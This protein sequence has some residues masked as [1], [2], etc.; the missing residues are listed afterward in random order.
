MEKKLKQVTDNIHETI[1][2]ST[3]ES[4]LISTPYFYRLHDIY[5]S[6]TVY[7]TFPTNRTKRYEHS[8]GTMEVASSM[9]YSA[10]SN[11][12]N[13][14]RNELF[15]YLKK[16][17]N[18]I[19][20]LSILQSGRQNAPYFIK[21]RD[22]IGKVF[23][24]ASS[25]KLQK[26]TRDAIRT[27]LEA[28]FFNDSA[29]EQFQFYPMDIDNSKEKNRESVENVFLYRCLLQAVRIVALFHDVGHPPYSHIL[30]KVI[31]DLY[32]KYSN[33]E[34]ESD[35]QIEQL[36]HFRKCLSDYV[37]KEPSKAY[38]CQAIYSH[39]SHVDGAFHER[40]GL[41]L[42]QSAIDD[43][44]PELINNIISS[45]KESY[46][47]IASSIYYIMVVEFTVAILAEKNM[48]FKSFHK[49]VDGIVDSDRLDYIMRDSL[50]S[51]VDWGRI[52]YKR[53]INSA[54]LVYIQ[55]TERGEIEETERPFVVAYPKKVVDDIEDLLLVRYKIFARINYHHRC[56]KTA[57]ALQTAVMELAED[58]LNSNSEMQCI[59]PDIHILWGALGANIGD[60]KARVIQWNDSWL[61]SVL[62]KALVKLNIRSEETIHLSALKENLE[63]IL[64]N[65]KRYYSL[66]KRGNDSKLFMDKIFASA[67]ITKEKITALE[68][69]EYQK[70]YSN[71]EEG[72]TVQ[73]ILEKP[74][75]NALDSIRRVRQLNKARQTGDLECLC[76]PLPLLDNKSLDEMIEEVL[77]I[78]INKGE[79]ADFKIIINKGKGKTGI[80]H[81]KD[82]LDEIYL[83]HGDKTSTFDDKVTLRDQIEAIERKVLWLYIYFV[84]NP[85]CKDIHGLAEKLIDE[86]AMRIGTEL[87]NRYNEL[88]G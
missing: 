71:E 52:P 15:K 12:D 39:T 78:Y 62:H 41:S 9:L 82:V 53:L 36:D 38:V 4:E 42:L 81:H 69:K 14:T 13:K 76:R 24:F 40:V 6:S 77:N 83:Y 72:V 84:P 21:C 45:N 18:E 74:G 87:K 66:L 37:T 86:M 75:V 64:L 19:L 5:Q 79:I 49:I 67:G 47:K 56:M 25:I 29:L 22:Q 43:V 58:Y 68:I 23:N 20:D 26:D 55:K 7:M 31:E 85:N 51:G 60:R 2:L 88:F 54:K 80:P 34:G 30:E 33:I 44:I 8:V 61:I 65:K 70:Y 35:W 63:E 50:N 32:E 17:F 10:V 73:D 59:S 27:A 46:C 3:L 48:V 28:G 16:Y 57:V 1:Y 11:A